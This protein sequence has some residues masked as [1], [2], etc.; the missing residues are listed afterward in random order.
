MVRPLNYAGA[1]VDQSRGSLVRLFNTAF[2]QYRFQDGVPGML[3]TVEAY[4][5]LKC[6]H[7]S[8]LFLDVVLSL[9][10][11]IRKLTIDVILIPVRFYHHKI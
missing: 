11:Y 9:F 7:H 6:L 1:F 3:L 2:L 4:K 10:Y 8:S 5:S